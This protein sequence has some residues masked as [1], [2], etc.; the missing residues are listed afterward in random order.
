MQQIALITDSNKFFGQTRKPWISIDTR[1]AIKFIQN[2]GY[3]VKEYT[4]ETIV[5]QNKL[6]QNSVII[7]T[8]HQ[9][10][11]RRNYLTDVIHYLDDGTNVFIPDKELLYCHENKGYQE[12]YKKKIGYSSLK[13]YYFTNYADT[14]N[15]NFNFPIVVKSVDGSNGKDVYLAKNE[16]ELKKCVKK[17]EKTKWQI[18][19]D[20]MRRKYLRK[21]KFDEYPEHD[22][23][24]DYELYRNYI[25]KEKNFILQEFVPDLKFD[26]RVL[27]LYDKYFVTKRHNRKN[28]FRASGAKKFDFNF[29]PDPALLD[30]ARD[31]YSHFPSSSLSI[32]VVHDGN[33][34]YLIEFQALHFGINV[35]VKNKNYFMYNAGNWQFYPIDKC[36]EYYLSTSFC[37]YLENL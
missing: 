13:S 20:L 31:V 25:L 12:L 18:H 22:D 35:F 3:N 4:F 14:K 19:V 23:R 16:I 21:K 28:D 17:L 10:I 26:Y 24:K 33:K 34:Y 15:Y 11:N 9:K 27:V 5:N 2:R 6:L 30:F 32:D 29:Q 37:D 7:Y 36:F 1:K 8:F